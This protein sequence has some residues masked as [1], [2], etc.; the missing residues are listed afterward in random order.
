VGDLLDTYA[1]I[2]SEIFDE[3]FSAVAEP[4]SEYRGLVA[5][6]ET[7]SRADLDDRC[8]LRDRAFRDQGITFALGDEVER[9][10]PLDLVPRLLSAADWSVIEAGVRQR[11]LALEAFLADIYGARAILRDG[12]IPHRTVMTSRHFHRCATGIDPITGVR[13]HVAGIDLVR[14]RD[15][16]FCVL[17]D[18]VRSPSGISYVVENR[19]AM[20]RVFP[21]L[22]ESHSV[23]PVAEYP[24]RLLAALRATAP[25]PISDPTVVV[26][27]PGV[28]NSAYFEHSFLARHMGIELVE[29]RDLICRDRIVYMRTTE[30]E[31][32]VDVVYRRVDDEFLDPVCFRPDSLVGCPGCSTP[33]APAT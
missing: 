20:T 23:R 30:G 25:R 21:E 14:G 19:R 4:R 17:E 2:G 26:L 11:V 16:R 27:T 32:Q 31:Q 10:F 1:P 9:P 5:H 22:F 15:G 18:N 12:V 6:L 8:A 33:R 28:H 24:T 13:I 7:M 29:G 3:M